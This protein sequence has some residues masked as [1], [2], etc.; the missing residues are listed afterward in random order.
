MYIDTHCHLDSNDYNNIDEVIRRVKNNIII[1]SGVDDRTNKEVIE[2]CNKF[3]NVYGTLGLH[4]NEIKD[5]YE[6]SLNFIEKNLTNSKIVG[7]GEIGL[8][9]HFNEVE[10]ELQ[11]EVFKKQIEIAKRNKKTIVIHSRDAALDTFNILKNSHLEDCKV[12]MHC[13]SYS[14]EMA[15]E[16]IK[17][18]VKLGIGG[19]VTFKNASKLKEIVKEINLDNLLLETDSPY[20]TPEPYRGQKN[21]PSFVIY[22]AK[23]IAKIKDISLEKVL[24]TTTRNAKCQFDL[25]IDL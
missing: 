20:L 25:N 12:V 1:V 14:L 17:M 9:Y 6:E 21:E 18:N 23:E 15:R 19:V 3:D 16:F 24:D 10:K 13:Y 7:V 5:Y 2:L 4:P 11:Q 8:D 22:I